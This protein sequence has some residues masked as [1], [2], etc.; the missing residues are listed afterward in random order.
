LAQELDVAYATEDHLYEAM[1]WLLKR[2]VINDN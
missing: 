2:Q 1:D